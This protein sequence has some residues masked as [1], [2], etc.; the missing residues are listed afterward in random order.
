MSNTGKK[1]VVIHNGSWQTVAGFS[2]RET[3]QCVIPSSYIQRDGQREAQIFGTFEMLDET[4]ENDPNS[5][6]YT[7]IDSRGLPY[8]WEALESQWRYIYEKQLQIDPSELPLIISVPASSSEVDMK[9]VHKYFELAFEKLRV[10]TLQIVVEPLAIAL[11]MSK[12][13]ALVIDIGARECKITPVIDGT[14]VK[15]GVMKSKFAGDFLDF[16][17]TELLKDRLP[18]AESS[19]QMW[20]NSQ[21]WIQQFKNTMLQVCDRNLVEVQRLHEEQSNQL[22]PVGFQQFTSNSLTQ[23]KNF[24]LKTANGSKQTISVEL[25]DCLKLPEYLFQP[26]LSNKDFPS[27]DGLCE[28][29]SKSI[30]KTGATVSSLGTPSGGGNGASLTLNE[31]GGASSASMGGTTSKNANTATNA[32]NPTN[33]P[34]SGIS[35]EQVYSILLTNVIITGSTSLLQG[36]EQRIVN[37]LSIR[38]PQYKLT[39]YANQILMDRKIQSWIAM[40]SM[41]NLPSWELGKWFSAS[42]YEFVKNC[43]KR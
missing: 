12:S 20:Y 27:S 11:S 39:T 43:A 15:S 35:P 25:K 38:F 30:R 3:P 42:D 7:I 2:N 1:C 19:C 26:Q 17:V 6:V 4:Q 14:V 34:S 5:N 29:M 32:S 41:S 23:P 13:S 37:E 28:L 22:Q 33:A 18:P 40:S 24:L 31:K 21:T 9:I 10:P 8:N 16:Q 36:M